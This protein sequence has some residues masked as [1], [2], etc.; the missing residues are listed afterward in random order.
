MNICRPLVVLIVASSTFLS[1]IAA[2]AVLLSYDGFNYAPAASDLLGNAGGSGFSSA[3][4]P[5]G[6]N[7]S[8]H[9]NYDIQSSSLSFG[10]LLTSGNRV[11][12]SAVAAV[13]GLTR[14]FS[15]P[16]GTPGTTHY[17]SFLLRPEGTLH[18]GAFNGFFGVVFERPVEP[19][20]FIGKPGGIAIDRYVLEDRGGAVQVAST[21]APVVGETVFLVLK[22]EFAAGNDQFTLYVNPIPG[23]PEPSSGVVKNN[24]DVGTVAGLT[25]YS[26]GAFS[27]DEFRLGETFAD[28]TP[29]PEPASWSLAVLGGIFL[30]RRRPRCGARLRKYRQLINV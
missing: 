6:F 27:V 11:Q 22:A 2:E 4:R 29:I 14:D 21:V 17:A 23:A 8:I 10:S 5:G 15:T 12:T 9:T 28:V 16:L 20:L 24:S 1:P 26:T 30:L 18:G 7:A 3:W 25:M 13:A 19:E